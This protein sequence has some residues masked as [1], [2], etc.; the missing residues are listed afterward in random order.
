MFQTTWH[1][2]ETKTCRKVLSRRLAWLIWTCSKRFE[3]CNNPWETRLWA[4]DERHSLGQS[5]PCG[6][7]QEQSCNV[8]FGPD[9]DRRIRH[10]PNQTVKLKPRQ[11]RRLLSLGL[12]WVTNVAL[13]S[14]RLSSGMW[15]QD[16]ICERPPWPLR[17]TPRCHWKD[18]LI[19]FAFGTLVQ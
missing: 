12:F 2:R 6:Q 10:P 9:H 18:S 13:E 8:P 5:Y 17:L 15:K 11:I 4:S 3:R 19:V 7:G 14:N 16:I 1:C